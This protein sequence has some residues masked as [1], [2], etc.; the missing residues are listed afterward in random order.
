MTLATSSAVL[1]GS[2]ASSHA[3][4]ICPVSRVLR[5]D[6]CF[7]PFYAFGVAN[8]LGHPGRDCIG[9]NGMRRC[10]DERPARGHI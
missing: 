8:V 7:V 3:D 5:F 6:Q 9:S 2:P 1:A 10:S 4:T